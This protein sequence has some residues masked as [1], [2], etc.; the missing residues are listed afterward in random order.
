MSTRHSNIMKAVIPVA[1]FGTRMLPVT[2]EVPKEMLPL[3]DKPLIQYVVHECISAGIHDIV[4]VTNSSKKS[5]RQYFDSNI[6]LETI[7]EKRKKQKILKDIQSICPPYV[8]IM[9]V[10]QELAQ[11]LGHALSCAWPIIG[12][13]PVTIILPDVVLDQYTSDLSQD[14]LAAMIKRFNQTHY[15]QIMVKPVNDV[16]NYGVVHCLDNQFKPANHSTIVDVIEKPIQHK[17]PSNLA[18]VGRYVL[19]A[20]I[21]PLLTQIT[22]GRN[23]EIQL[24]DAIALLIKQE[25]TEAYFL[26]GESYDCGDKLGYMQAFFKYSMHHKL[27][28]N[29][30]QAWLHSTQC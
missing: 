8:T 24:T 7:L 4:L 3:V 13:N 26:K 15:S 29:K 28:G 2:K 6:E 18:I 19:S 20:K 5:I 22:P 14:N 10:Q 16:T 11:G 25:K 17:T 21:W 30:F 27:L 12:Y 9:Q 23:R 1:G